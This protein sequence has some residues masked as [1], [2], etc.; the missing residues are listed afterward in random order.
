MCVNEL[1]NLAYMGDFVKVPLRRAGGELM[2]HM[3]LNRFVI[4]WHT[5]RKSV[6]G[7]QFF[8]IARRGS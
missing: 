5:G 4:P 6:T 3:P 7:N 8:Q 2:V 1:P